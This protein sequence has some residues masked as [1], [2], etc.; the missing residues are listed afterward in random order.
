MVN[1]DGVRRL[2]ASL[3][4]LTLRTGSPKTYD[5]I[6]E[7]FIDT[8]E[9]LFVYVERT[10]NTYNKWTSAFLP[11]M[12]LRLVAGALALGVMAGIWSGW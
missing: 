8:R 5:S 1:A 9:Q 7:C 4:A 10:G 2:P 3:V 6:K 12:V 11:L